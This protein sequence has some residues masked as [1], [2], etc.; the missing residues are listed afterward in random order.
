VISL[1]VVG[2]APLIAA[3]LAKTTMALGL[4]ARPSAPI[5]YNTARAT[6]LDPDQIDEVLTTTRAVRKRLD[7][8]RPVPRD[9]VLD[10]VR[11][12]TEAPASRQRAR[13][14]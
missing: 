13:H 6:D 2:S 1:V 8:T 4:G 3:N 5:G 14:P 12:S 11:V 9:L 7:L 10:C